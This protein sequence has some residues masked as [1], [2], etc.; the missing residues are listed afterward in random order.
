MLTLSGNDAFTGGISVAAGTLLVNGSTSSSSTVSIGATGILGG[1][2]TIAGS[3]SSLGSVAPGSPG[4]P[5]TLSILGSLN[6]DP[7]ATASAGIL[8]IDLVG[9]GTSDKVA[10]LTMGSTVNLAGAT[11]SLTTSG[12]INTGDTFTILTVPG[13]PTG[14]FTGGST[15]TVGS[16][17]FSISYTGGLSHQDVVLTALA[18]GTGPSLVSIVRDAG[19]TYLNNTLDPAQHSM[20]ESVVYSFRS[21]ISLSASN[22]SISA[23]AAAGTTIVPTLVVTPNGSSTVWTVTFTGAGVN[24]TTH[25]IGDGEYRLSLTGVSGLADSSFDF[26]RLL[27]DMD[28]NGLVNIADFSTLV[29]TFLRATNDPLY[30]GAADLDG[31]GTIG[32]GDISL[33]V[34]NF[35]HSVP[36][37]LPPNL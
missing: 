24:P 12:T 34:S 13:G 17:S 26:F 1:S 30:L 4:T 6:L 20:V 29:G 10:V 3:V 7:I 18:A 36:Q 33:L 31:D 25:S 35:L 21:A 27:G 23:L 5:G 37:P 19:N 15:I 16:R 22:F 32:I 11:L 14:T 28:G 2:G 8:S 9:G